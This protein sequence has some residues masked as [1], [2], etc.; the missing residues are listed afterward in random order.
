[1]GITSFFALIGGLAGGFLMFAALGSPAPHPRMMFDPGVWI[2]GGAI[3]G[4][5]IG[6]A[7]H[8]SWLADPRSKMNSASPTEDN[9]N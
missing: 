6:L 1:M 5:L 3:I 7:G 2:I 4:A 9:R 8:L